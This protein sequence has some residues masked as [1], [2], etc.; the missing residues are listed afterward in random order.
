[1]TIEVVSASAGSGKTHFLAEEVA[2]AVAA[3]TVRPHAVLAV[4]FT[5]HAANELRA[6]LRARVESDGGTGR[7]IELA[8]IG[9]VHSVAASWLRDLALEL[10]T[11]PALEVLSE[12]AA[13][14]LFHAALDEATA[15]DADEDRSFMRRLSP[16]NWAELAFEMA[17][18]ARANRIAPGD[19]AQHAER[20][21][22]AVM[23]A[24]PAP[25]EPVDLKKLRS[26]LE[27]LVAVPVDSATGESTRQIAADVLARLLSP[28][29]LGW[30]ILDRLSTLGGAAAQRDAYERV[31]AVA[32]T[33]LSDPELGADI[34]AAIHHVVGAAARALD[35]YATMKRARAVVDFTDLE[36]QFVAALEN[37]SI[38]AAV[39][40]ELDL[41][42]VDEL[43]D[44]SPLQVDLFVRL[45]SLAKR[46]IW[47]GDMKQAIFGFRGTDPR[48]MVGLIQSVTT[49]P[50]I[51]GQSWRSRPPLVDITN[52]V[53]TPPFEALGVPSAQVVLAPARPA[54]DRALGVFVERWRVHGDNRAAQHEALASLV[55]KFLA[56]RQVQ[57]RDAK[58]APRLARPG[59][60]AILCRTQATCLAVAQNLRAAGHEV[61]GPAVL[62]AAP[63][64]MLVLA[65][66][67]L[68]L[69]A[70]DRLAHAEVARI[71]DAR[72]D[73]AHW[74]ARA[75]DEPDK[76]WW[77]E[78]R[79]ESL[80][81]SVRLDEIL[82]RP[83]LRELIAAWGSSAT[84]V[85]RL[86]LVRQRAHAYERAV[87]EASIAGFLEWILH[88]GAEGAGATRV[89]SAPDRVNVLTW[90]ASK[91]LEWPVV[92]LYDLHHVPSSSPCGVMVEGPSKVD[93][94]HPLRGRT[95]RFWPQAVSDR[96][97]AGPFAAAMAASVE[98]R[99]AAQLRAE[100]ELRLL[101]VAWTR[102]RDRLVL[103]ARPSRLTEGALAVLQQGGVP[104]VR[105]PMVRATWG[106]RSFDLQV[107]ESGPI[108]SPSRGAADTVPIRYELVR[109]PARVAPSR[110]AGRGRVLSVMELGPPLDLGGPD[111]ARRLGIALHEFLVAVVDM[112][113][114][115][116]RGDVAARAMRRNDLGEEALTALLVAADRFSVWLREQPGHS[117]SAV[118]VEALCDD[119]TRV[120]GETDLVIRG[121]DDF[122]MVDHKVH[123]AERDV[124]LVAAADAAAQLGMYASLFARAWDQTCAGLY[125]HL[126]AQG[127]V[128]QIAAKALT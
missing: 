3:G 36:E 33:Y 20:S 29:P 44:S 77:L 127:V 42:V 26:A 96:Q 52:H 45:A 54:D 117:M 99:A 10:G 94:G 7:G 128:A 102:A 115:A 100:E 46:T 30:D 27:A 83:E 21:V 118:P 120:S 69:D 23:A 38:A 122:V 50:R 74:A 82:A 15:I 73:G 67:R 110:A 119:G 13:K 70:D 107:R 114:E 1:M 39:G 56:D 105:E 60:V 48:L 92:V 89:A 62:D 84:R 93:A 65:I 17:T 97:T 111:A 55:T 53:F 104:L 123:I 113:A 49:S 31:R 87:P 11:S 35:A 78:R 4:T 86:E 32:S 28:R 63:E 8:R 71:L 9:T 64:V 40:R 66:L 103:A 58:G 124:A 68:T 25:T 19:L 90:H 2:A 80:S 61:A 121:A 6:R 112:S 95:L 101:Y 59:D 81:V 85:A 116:A 47:V 106:R 108:Q 37:R 75:F 34:R 72:P 91:G 16:Q 51:L 22:A 41:F 14:A 109:R 98:G 24:L 88:D 125:V 57:V 76:G 79:S 126:P 18:Y 43:Q 5:T 12:P